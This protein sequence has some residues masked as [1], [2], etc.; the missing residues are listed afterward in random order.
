MLTN[1]T[2]SNALA[3]VT[4]SVD[5][6]FVTQD[7]AIFATGYSQGAAVVNLG[8]TQ[9]VIDAFRGV[10]S[11]AYD[12]ANNRIEVDDGS[13][14]T[15]AQSSVN[16]NFA[17]S[18]HG[19]LSGTVD[20]NGAG[21][22]FTPDAGDG[23]LVLGVAK[24]GATFSAALD[25]TGTI[26]FGAAGVPVVTIPKDFS[27]NLLA[28]TYTGIPL[29]GNIH[30]DGVNDVYA[31][32]VNGTQVALTT[33]GTVGAN[34][35]LGGVALNNVTLSGSVVLDPLSNTL[36]FAQ[37][38]TLG[39]DFGTRHISFTATDNAGGRLTFGTSGLT[40]TTASGDGGLILSVTENGVTRQAS[41]NVEGTINYSL[42]G[43]I[44]LAQG[45]VVQNIFAD[46]N[47]LTIT[48][49]TEASGSVF[50]DPQNGLYITP[51]TP[52]ALTVSLQTGDLEV[53][54]FTSITGTINYTNGIITA[55]DGAQ[56]HLTVYDIWET[57]LRTTG[58]TASIQFTD[59]RT[60]YTANEGATFVLDYLDGTTLEIQNGSYSDIYATE[61]SDAIELVSAGSI[62]RANDGEFFFTLDTAG[63]YTLNGM[64]VTTTEDG[65]QVRLV[66]Y[67]TVI[68]GES[69]Y[70]PLNETAALVISSEGVV[71]MNDAVFVSSLDLVSSADLAGDFLPNYDNDFAN[72]L[73]IVDAGTLDN[74]LSEIL[75]VNAD[76]GE[77][78]FNPQ[79]D[80]LSEEQI[81]IAE[82]QTRCDVSTN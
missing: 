30:G 67:T 36:T 51:S 69:A 49:N 41:L 24:D 19:K 73:Q 38:S 59:D 47:I 23:W 72:A 14:F 62:F 80:K 27:L 33:N 5:G 28:T 75:P 32:L 78:D 71:D 44:T 4:A 13:Y 74:Q 12:T 50:F 39:V 31:T 58:G 76:F 11:I 1:I 35:N 15:F 56:A 82:Q 79:P 57:E 2:V 68:V 40:F 48:A 66:D 18:A 54:K 16:A 43:S 8:T 26:T 64:N 53:A 9:T 70:T 17:L 22:S 52:D 7:N 42:D 21:L 60:V 63:N 46:G 55:G 81:I 61:T 34:L 65:V 29:S 25:G 77:I 37:G 20:L 6:S 3:S 10:G 45:T